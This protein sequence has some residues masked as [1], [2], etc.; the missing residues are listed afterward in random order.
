MLAHASYYNINEYGELPITI[1]VF[2]GSEWSEVAKLNI[3]YI[4]KLHKTHNT[5]KFIIE[6]PNARAGVDLH[7]IRDGK[8]HCIGREIGGHLQWL[9]ETADGICQINRNWDN[10]LMTKSILSCEWKYMVA[11]KDVY[12]LFNSYDDGS[13]YTL[14]RDGCDVPPNLDPNIHIMGWSRDLQ[15]TTDI[16]S[17]GIMHVHNAQYN[18]ITRYDPRISMTGTTVYS[19]AARGEHAHSMFLNDHTFIKVWDDVSI[20]MVDLRSMA[21][22]ALPSLT[23]QEYTGGDIG[24][25][26]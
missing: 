13:I 14:V 19:E 26:G 17:D 8:S 22:Y 20:D 3:N 7:D 4:Q 18:S 21:T 25:Y 9:Y 10:R 1:N 15:I 23:S 6:V 16:V 2:N 11:P 5:H 24:I 12:S